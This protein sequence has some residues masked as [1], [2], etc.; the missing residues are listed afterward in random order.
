MVVEAAENELMLAVGVGAI[1]VVV[2]VVVLVDVEDVLV[3]VLDVTV[4]VVVVVDVVVLVDVELLLVVVPVGTVVV[5]VDVLVVVLGSVVPGGILTTPAGTVVVVPH[6]TM[7]HFCAV[8]P[9][10]HFLVVRKTDRVF[11]LLQIAREPVEDGID[12]RLLPDWQRAVLATKSCLVVSFSQM[13]IFVG[14]LAGTY[15]F[16]PEAHRFLMAAVTTPN[17]LLTHTEAV[18]PPSA[19]PSWERKRNTRVR[20]KAAPSIRRGMTPDTALLTACCT[21][22]I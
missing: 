6:E 9:F 14:V 4:G 1:L 5:V 12:T 2:D 11:E 19:R 3:D 17:L 20:A 8:V 16:D 7:I 18:E 15:F 13:K 22:Q 21:G 10:I